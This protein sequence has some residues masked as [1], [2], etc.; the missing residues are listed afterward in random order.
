VLV[1]E[2]AEQVLRPQRVEGVAGSRD[3]LDTD[4][5][6]GEQSVDAASEMSL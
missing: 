4:V 5:A 1:E 3:D 6:V 2:L